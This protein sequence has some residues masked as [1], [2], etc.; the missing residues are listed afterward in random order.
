MNSIKIRTLSYWERAV[1]EGF[2]K[3][4]GWTSVTNLPR[5]NLFAQTLGWIKEPG[6]KMHTLEEAFDK[7][8]ECQ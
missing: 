7:E 6:M 8:L 3:E 1:Q 5:D 2:L 4:R